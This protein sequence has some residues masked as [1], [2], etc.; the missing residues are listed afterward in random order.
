MGR[1][2]CTGP[3]SSPPPSYYKTIHFAILPHMEVDL[4]FTLTTCQHHMACG[5]VRILTGCGPVMTG[6]DHGCGPAVTG[7]G[8]I[9]TKCGCGCD[10]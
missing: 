5:P 10:L 6:C 8:P 4:P 3:C 1:D 7:R 2:Q 9:V